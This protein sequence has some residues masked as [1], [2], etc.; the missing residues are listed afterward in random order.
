MTWTPKLTIA[1]AAALLATGVAACGDDDE[2]TKPSATQP[3]ARSGYSSSKKPGEGSGKSKAA[4]EKGADKSK[5]ADE[6]GKSS[7]SGPDRGD[8]LGNFVP[9]QH[10][11]SGGGAAKFRVKGGDNS[12]QEYG[13]EAGGSDFEEVS[14]ALHNFLD[15][16]AIGDWTA[17]CNYLASSL[18]E[19]L[20]KLAQQSKEGS[21]M[22]CGE[23]LGNLTPRQEVASPKGLLVKEAEMADVG[24]VRVEGDRAFVIYRSYEDMVM[25]ISMVKEDGWKVASLGGIP[26]N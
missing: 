14:T 23:M 6:E 22:D 2:T 21:A 26:L 19:S 24:S 8:D 3:E 17:A 4:D 12:V 15:A 13:E 25:A 18:V 11:D 5:G 1:A 7:T 16:R 9:K 10:S 20:E